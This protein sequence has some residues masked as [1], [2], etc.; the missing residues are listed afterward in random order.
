MGNGLM[1][2]LK[3]AKENEKFFHCNDIV[4][5]ISKIYSIQEDKFL[6]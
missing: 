3:C 2:T 1:D 5:V 6:R 4:Q